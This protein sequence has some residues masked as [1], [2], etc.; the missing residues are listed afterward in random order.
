MFQIDGSLREW[1]VTDRLSEITIPVLVTCGRY[2]EA[3]PAI[4]HELANGI[5]GAEIR[6]FENSSHVAHIEEA[7]AF[8]DVVEEFLA[9]CDRRRDD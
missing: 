8:L 1:H 7:E 3:T 2:D 6:V 9:R 5:L 4:A